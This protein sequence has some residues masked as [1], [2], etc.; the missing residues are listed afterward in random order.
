MSRIDVKKTYKLFIGG[1]FPRSESGRSYEITGADGK[2]IANPALAS[3]KDLRDAVT[4]AKSAL[5]GWS[6]ATAF[7]RGQILY[8]IAEI[9]EGRRDQFVA[10]ILALEGGT[11]KAATAQVT[12]AID[13]WVWYAG[14]CDKISTIA[15][16]TNP[17]A[18]PYYNFTIPEE[19]GVVGVIA[20]QKESL[21]G[22]IAA[23]A[24]VISTG[25]TAV[26]I[27]SEKRPLPAITLSEALATSDL[28]AGVLN[29][30]T[31]KVSELAPWLASHMEIDGLDVTGVNSKIESE[32][33]I[34]GAE[35]LKRIHR[36]NKAQSPERMLA[37]MEAKT[38]WHPIGV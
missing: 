14:W 1:Q 20:E 37:F 34:A 5:P 32:L 8:R 10:E 22:L 23:I 35:N 30:L 29:I 21:L 26:V 7:N 17:I 38:V 16:A 4:A 11:T 15:G 2:F 3:R 9:M 25:N 24:P 31:G 28:P 27:A 33:R 18:G 36:F 6:G 13:L 19:L 12:E